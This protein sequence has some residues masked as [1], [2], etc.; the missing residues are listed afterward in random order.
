MFE[1]QGLPRNHVLRLLF[2]ALSQ[3][4]TYDSGYPISSMSTTPHSLGVEIYSKTM[5]R[6]AGRY[7]TFQGTETIEHDVIRMIGDMLRV[8]QPFGTSTSGGTESNILAMLAAREIHKGQIQYPTIIAPKTVH[9]SVD[10]AAWLLG[11][12]LHKTD[13]DDQYRARPEEIE[14]AITKETVGIVSTAGTTYLGQVD[15]IPEIG[16]IA[17]KHQLPFHVD[18]AFGG[19]VLPFL[20]G[21]GYPSPPFDFKIKGVTSISVDPHKMG[22]APIPASILISNNNDLLQAITMHVPYLLGKSAYQPSLLG[23]RP[24]GPILAT[25]AIMKHLGRQGYR[26]IIRT[27]MK[28]TMLAKERVLEHPKLNL[29]IHPIMNILGIEIKGIQLRQVVA[30]MEQKGWRMA[31]SPL[32]P[33]LRMV[34]MPHLNPDSINAFFDELSQVLT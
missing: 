33:T 23:T 20:E 10:K 16:S 26:Q 2:N 1:E 22:L 8:S 4:S 34:I 30:A 31:L 19:F 13:V 11:L 28:N 18:A 17:D 15:P 9:S 6:N 3:D 32:P 21:V 7:Y 27:C 12:R 24:A 29:A 14:K 5:D 25:W